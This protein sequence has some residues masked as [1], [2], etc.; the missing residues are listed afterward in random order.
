MRLISRTIFLAAGLSVALPLAGVRPSAAAST[1][2]NLRVTQFLTSI[3]GQPVL[4]PGHDEAYEITLYNLGPFT[5]TDGV[6][7][8]D[9]IPPELT[10]LAPAAVSTNTA[11]ATTASCTTTGH[12]VQCSF[13]GMSFALDGSKYVVVRIPIAIPLGTQVGIPLTNDVQ[14]SSTQLPGPQQVR[15][16]NAVLPY[17]TDLGVTVGS[18]DIG[19]G[20]SGVLP[21]TIE[22]LTPGEK[23]V[24]P[25]STLVP[26][27]TRV[28]LPTSTAIVLT[29]P[30]TCTPVGVPP[31]GTSAWDCTT[32]TVLTFGVP[33]VFNF[34]ASGS[35]AAASQSATVTG[36]IQ[37]N[38]GLVD[39]LPLNNVAAGL[40]RVGPLAVNDVASTNPNVPI[41]SSVIANDTVGGGATFVQ[42]TDPTHGTLVFNN[43]GTYTY[44]P[45][46]GYSGTDSFTYSVTNPGMPGFPA[47]A[48]VNLSVRPGAVDDTNSV[49]YGQPA[50][51]S[52]ST[53]DTFAVG[54]VFSVVTPPGHGVLTINADGTYVFTAEVGFSGIVEATYKLTNPDGTTTSAKLTI[55]VGP[56]ANGGNLVVEPGVTSTSNIA[57]TDIYAPG[58]V[59]SKT[60]PA[61]HG[62]IVVQP[63]GTYLYTPNT[64]Y[65]GPDSVPYVVTNP[66]GMSSSSVI[67]IHVRPKA[68]DDSFT[69]TQPGPLVVCN[70]T[71][72]D[73]YATGA[74]FTLTT[75]TAHGQ[76]T[77]NADGTCTYKPDAG[78]AG[79]DSFTYTVRNPD[80]SSSTATVIIQVRK[81][82]SLPATGSRTRWSLLTAAA[83]LAVGVVLRRASRRSLSATSS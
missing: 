27:T 52:V 17:P 46:A 67:T 75:G 50:T 72:N 7:L 14:F 79:Q 73:I 33:Y 55:H 48:T 5:L 68:N 13:N 63:D 58:A 43:D 20:G 4:Y 29:P 8:I 61:T 41:A 42:T 16:S 66:D 69:V 2:T 34:T 40:I 53:N 49:P 81:G 3:T 62:A 77:V 38:A 39:D 37:V 30:A 71:G 65:S 26:V 60:G 22:N 76:V 9:D 11:G 74:A 47:T 19:A 21:V 23:P 44:T 6:T 51:G 45:A 82:G 10:V 1:A 57:S 70:L 31:V 28:T 83:L 18:L 36:T 15:V 59:F 80:G 35:L 24:I 54:A 32:P 78:F 56:K 12:K 64:G 25:E